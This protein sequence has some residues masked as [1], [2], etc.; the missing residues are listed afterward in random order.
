MKKLNPFLP[1]TI[2]MILISGLLLSACS[3]KIP[4]DLVEETGKEET[5]TQSPEAYPLIEDAEADAPI[6]EPSEDQA[7]FPDSTESEKAPDDWAAAAGLSE[8]EIA[9]LL[10]MREEEKLAHD[11]Y[12]SLYDRWGLPVFQNIASSE[13][14]HTEAV[15]NLLKKYG[16]Q[17]PAD[18]SRAGVFVNEDLQE[19]YDDLIEK[20]DSSL[21]DALTVGA[22]IEEIDI[23]DLQSAI[24]ETTAADIARVYENLLKGSE[25]HLRAFTS[26]LFG[27]TGET[28]TPQYL[29]QE[30]YTAILEAESTRRGGYGRGGGRRP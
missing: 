1:L 19:M 28:Y 5:G 10:F 29:S 11:V 13:A 24:E 17:D 8:V 21:G 6:S 23:L 7:D 15:K 16:I 18:T 9:H 12:L 2:P 3:P 14:N 27:Q 4:P 20:G 25:N 22:A 26:T 30:A